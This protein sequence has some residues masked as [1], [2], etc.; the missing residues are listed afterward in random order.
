VKYSKTHAWVELEDEK[1]AIIGISDKAQ[2]LLNEIVYIE[3]P[4]EGDEFEQDETIASLESID[5]AVVNFH[6]PI[7]GEII[8]V[9]EAL[10]YSPD[11]INRSPEGDGWIVKMRI[12]I[13]KELDILMTPEQYERYEGDDFDEEEDE[14]EDDYEE[15][16][17]EY[18]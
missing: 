2:H 10:G 12:E 16:E 5:G 18:F 7:T 6:S 11:L 3:L 4:E 13:P 14:Y 17:E 8:E 1:T 15:E 9:N